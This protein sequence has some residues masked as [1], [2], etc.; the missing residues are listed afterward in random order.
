[1]MMQEFFPKRKGNRGASLLEM[2]VAISIFTLVMVTTVELFA[3]MVSTKVEFDRIRESHEKAQ[4][5]IDSLS[6]SIRSGVVVDPTS[7]ETVSSIRIYDYSQGMCIE[8]A[9]AGEGG[10]LNRSS[11]SIDRADCD[12]TAALDSSQAITSKNVTGEFDVILPDE[13]SNEQGRVTIALVLDIPGSE[14]DG[15]RI[16]TSVSMRNVE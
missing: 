1:M 11:A 9:F 5:A 14:T 7:D 13:S 3:R 8:Y 15:T 16:Q 6:K 4:I 12:A 2:V 10:A